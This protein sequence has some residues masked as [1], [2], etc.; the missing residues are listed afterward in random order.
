MSWVFLGKSQARR[1]VPGRRQESA[2]LRGED[3]RGWMESAR[4]SLQQMSVP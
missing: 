1:P 2:G 3:G 4:S